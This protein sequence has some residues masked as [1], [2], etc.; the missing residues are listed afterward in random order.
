[1]A[2]RSFHNGQIFCGER[3]LRQYKHFEA[4]GLFQQKWNSSH[5]IVIS[6][7]WPLVVTSY[8]DNILFRRNNL[9]QQIRWAWLIR[10][11]ATLNF[12]RCKHIA[13]LSR[14]W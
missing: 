8:Y 3:L 10:F 7:R 4:R 6:T 14:L 13:T 2:P 1:V 12:L 11:N 9:A 5:Q